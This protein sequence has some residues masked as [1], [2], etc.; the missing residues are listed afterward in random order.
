MGVDSENHTPVPIEVRIDNLRR[1][2]EDDGFSRSLRDAFP[3][4]NLD[5]T[6]K[7]M[8]AWI[9]ANPQKSNKKNWKGFANSW[10]SREQ[11]RL[12]EHREK[13][14]SSEELEE[15]REREERRRKLRERSQPI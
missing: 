12:G 6:C 13:T 14:M 4:I 7:R 8:E 9:R 11:V 2:F 3:D 1:V 10:C 15:Q 5:V